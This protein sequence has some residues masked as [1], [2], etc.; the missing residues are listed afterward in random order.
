MF[1]LHANFLGMQVFSLPLFLMKISIQMQ[2]EDKRNLERFPLKEVNNER[3][4]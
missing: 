3:K 2:K 4:F 1:K